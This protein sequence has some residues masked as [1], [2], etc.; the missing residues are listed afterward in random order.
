ME[1]SQQSKF[2]CEFCGKYAVK[3]KAVGIWGCSEN[4]LKLDWPSRLRICIGIAKD[5]HRQR[6]VNWIN[7]TDGT[8]SAFDITTKRI[9]HSSLHNEYWRMI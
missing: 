8:S 1:V 4:Q 2:F 9:L 6:I 7:A 3:R 5:V